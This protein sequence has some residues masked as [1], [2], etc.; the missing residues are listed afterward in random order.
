LAVLRS[1]EFTQGFILD[2]D[3]MPD[4]FAGRW[5]IAS[6]RWKGTESEWPTPA[7]A[8][9]YFDRAVRNIMRDTKTGLVTVQIERR[10]PVKAALWANELV[11]RLN[12]EM[13]AR[14]IAS[15]N[16]SVGYLE[17]ELSS[18]AAVE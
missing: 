10:D 12:A 16:A 1:R 2:Q 8:V 5:D 6:K 3:V 17:K 4:L 15:T 9:K 18:T 11:A 13:R 14:A 7:E